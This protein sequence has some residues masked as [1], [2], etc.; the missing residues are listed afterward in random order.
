MELDNYISVVWN[1]KYYTAGEFEIVMQT[2]PER[3]EKVV[4]DNF[5]I[6][7][8]SD[9]IAVIDLIIFS[10]DEDQGAI[11]TVKGSFGQS[12]LKR[13]IIWDKVTLS[14]NMETAIHNL[15]NANAV[16]PSNADR[17][18]TKYAV[19]ET[20]TSE[21]D[22]T[23]PSDYLNL[24][25]LQIFGETVITQAGTVDSTTGRLSGLQIEGTMLAPM[26]NGV[27]RTFV[28]LTGEGVPYMYTNPL[29]EGVKANFFWSKSECYYTSKAR[30]IKLSDL[31]PENFSDLTNFSYATGSSYNVLT[32]SIDLLDSNVE[33]Q[34]ILCSAYVS[35]TKEQYNN[36]GFGVSLFDNK[37]NFR[38]VVTKTVD[39]WVSDQL[40]LIQDAQHHNE[41]VW[42][43]V[44]GQ[45][46]T[47][48]GYYQM[49]P[50]T[51][52]IY[53]LPLSEKI[54]LFN[55]NLNWDSNDLLTFGNFGNGYG[56]AE[57]TIYSD[58][59]ENDYLSLGT[60]A[61]LTDQI[62]LEVYGDNL[63]TKVEEILE[64]YQCGLK[65]RYDKSTNKIYLD[66]YLGTDRTA[67]I[68]FSENMDNLESY[69]VNMG[70]VE[71]NLAL[72]YSKD[73]DAEY[74]GVAGASAGITRREIFIN[75]TDN[76]G[77]VGADYTQQLITEGTLS[78]QRVRISIESEIDADSYVY[79][80]Q[81]FLGDI[82]QLVIKDLGLSYN[83]RILEVREYQDDSGYTIDLVLGE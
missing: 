46:E 12:L 68:V 39:S 30:Y 69:T 21:N 67:N 19:I 35:L 3:I 8:L 16:A 64:L 61:G 22:I 57:Y 9:E 71:A 60:K 36:G 40:G 13:R 6:N 82:V 42:L 44:V 50:E 81:Y 79:R 38:A 23:F 41:Y 20:I 51:F 66:T 52:F 37:L 24:R 65:A 55:T 56:Y 25:Q 10:K 58:E 73:G 83:I 26:L 62:E 59:A 49:L 63:L 47:G 7:D 32:F 43:L 17:A 80:L 4:R 18:L 11:M 72:V 31:Y 48:A 53:S 1:N 45:W 2:T 54:N 74:T 70:N 78:L 27:M 5:I 29:A 77:Y 75:K 28:T 76:P 15:I 34:D 33:D 14:G